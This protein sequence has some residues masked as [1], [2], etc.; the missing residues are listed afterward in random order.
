M[1]RYR[2][3][4]PQLS[5]KLFLTDGGLET[6]MIYHQKIDLPSFAA[7]D[8]LLS[9]EGRRALIDYFVSYASVAKANNLGFVFENVT[10]AL[11]DG[12]TPKYC[13]NEMKHQNHENYFHT[14]GRM[15]G[16]IN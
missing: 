9:S 15:R 1:T 16:M 6:T 8:L 5:D 2:N 13:V 4:L 10:I 3:S 14:F 7:F 11:K 12:V